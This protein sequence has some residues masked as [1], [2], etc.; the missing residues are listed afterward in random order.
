MKNITGLKELSEIIAKAI[1]DEPYLTKENLAPKIEAIIKG[2]KPV[3]LQHNFNK[4]ENPN[5]LAKLKFEK[6]YREYE[7]KFWKT[8]I[9]K[10][11]GKDAM[12]NFYDKKNEAESIWE[13]KIEL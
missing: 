11:V 7:I 12:Q 8:E 5:K 2:F 10:I 6:E 4:I 13:N 3:L 1:F 9:E